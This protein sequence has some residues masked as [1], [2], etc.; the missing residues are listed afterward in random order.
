[1]AEILTTLALRP[2][3]HVVDRDDRRRA[4]HTVAAVTHPAPGCWDVS[5]VDTTAHAVVGAQH[6]WLD[7]T[8]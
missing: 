4:E 8:P 2:G 3:M 6:G 5:F 1:M 7:V